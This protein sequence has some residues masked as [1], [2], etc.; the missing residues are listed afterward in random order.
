MNNGID[1]VPFHE[2]SL[3]S[4]Q[5][6]SDELHLWYA[7]LNWSRVQREDMEEILSDDERA[8]ANRF[9]FERDRQR[10][11][12]SHGLL[13]RILEGYMR[14]PASSLHFRYTEKGKPE[15]PGGELRFSLSHSSEM[16]VLAF[17]R[18]SQVGVDVEDASRS[19]DTEQI[20]KS[21]FS[22]REYQAFSAIPSSFKLEVF[23]N[24]WT[25]K[26]AYLKAVGVGLSLPLNSVEVTLKP[27]EEPGILAVHGDGKSA[28]SWSLYNLNLPSGYI[29]AVAIDG[30][31]SRISAWSLD[32]SCLAS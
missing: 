3:A 23:L 4:L 20:A 16:V 10:F 28:A 26:E 22:R 25:R 13:R 11:V 32:G 5:L 2:N 1:F 31:M 7:N 27:C 6:S 9:A 30:L 24:C 17:T 29:G 19:L 8:R 18:S 12:V 21:H 14:V 15:L